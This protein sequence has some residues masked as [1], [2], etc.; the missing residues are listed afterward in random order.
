MS[1]AAQGSDEAEFLHGP[2]LHCEDGQLCATKEEV[3][4]SRDYLLRE[5]VKEQPD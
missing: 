5:E 2:S 1:A 3:S 4:T